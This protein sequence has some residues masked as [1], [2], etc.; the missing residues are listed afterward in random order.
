MRSNVKFPTFIG[1]MS[2]AIS[3][4]WS[5]VF[6]QNQSQFSRLQ[7][8]RALHATF[9]YKLNE[10]AGFIFQVDFTP[11]HT[12]KSTNISFN[13]QAITVLDRPISIVSLWGTVMGKM[14]AS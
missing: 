4:C 10:D 1:D 6:Y 13:E 3:W 5:T 9:S 7:D 11:A 14:R 12:A 8:F 2:H